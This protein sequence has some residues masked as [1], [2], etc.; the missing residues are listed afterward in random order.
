MRTL[1]DM[2]SGQ[3]MAVVMRYVP[4]RDDMLDIIQDTF[5]KIFTSIHQFSFRGQGSL[6]A[7]MSRIAANMA[8]DFLRRRNVLS[9]N[10]NI[11]DI[12]D[13]PEP[14][15]HG[16][17]D[18]TLFELI[19]RLPTGYRVVLNMYVFEQMSHKEIAEKLGIKESTSASQ[20]FH[21]KKLLGKMIEQYNKQKQP[22]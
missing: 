15:I 12:A 11:P 18:A 9:L 1:Y 13:E 7:W 17:S 10:T 19:G 14:D 3:I 4:N 22:L 21:A 16:I 8:L 5:V 6:K 20:F 2:Y